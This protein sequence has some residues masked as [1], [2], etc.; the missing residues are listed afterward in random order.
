[1][2]KT[3]TVYFASVGVARPEGSATLPA[4][5]QRMLAEFDLKELSQGQAVPIKMHLGGNLGY[6]TIHPL[7]VRMVVNAVK[8]AGGK[9]FVVEAG[10]GTVAA[11]ADRG[12]TAETLGC[13]IVAAGGPYD[14]YVVEREVGFR[15]LDKLRIY[16]TIWDAP[17]LI[18][19]SHVKGH[20]ACGYGGAC[21]NIAM[22]CV[23]AKTRAKIHA[24]EGGI[25]WDKNA[26]IFCGRCVKACDSD[27]ITLDKKKKSLD[28]FFHNCRF[29]RHCVAACPTKA[30]VMR[31][32][33]GFRYF[34]E[35]MALTTKTVLDSFKPGRVLHIN[36][37][38]QITMFCD[39]WGI[40]TPSLVPDIGIM[41]S[42][43]MVALESA[44]L[45]AIKTENLIPG[46]LIGKKKLH[47][48]SHL[49]ERIHGKDPWLQVKAL[50]AHGVG[51]RKHVVKEVG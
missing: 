43:D 5:L 24:L 21:K 27:A 9:P 17:C 16:G 18:N 14:T 37:L 10:F 50:E 45:N 32:E 7:L 22:G 11:A 46:S 30:L 28:I 1:M 20:G 6:S 39:C 4:K 34:Q 49:F 3:S 13:P 23:D 42:T 33:S 15:Q 48:G 47:K 36:V 2:K 35:G 40:T 25:D 19:L 31:E 51:S 38:T 12:Y 44:C 8:A 26:C 29:C 41:A